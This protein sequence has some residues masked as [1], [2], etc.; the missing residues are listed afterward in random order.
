MN[1]DRFVEISANVKNYR[2]Y[3]VYYQDQTSQRLVLYKPR[4]TD[5]EDV[6]VQTGKVP[7]CLYVSLSD[8]LDFVG[9]R[10][11]EYN[12]RLRNILKGEPKASKKLLA[13]VLE[14]GL[15]V[16]VAEI[17]PR[18]RETVD[19]VLKEYM[20]DEAIVTKMIEVTVKDTST[21]VHSVNVM[22]HCLGYARQSEYDYSDLKSFGLM[23]L[24]HDVGKLNIPDSILKAPRRL[25]VEEFDL[26]KTHPNHGYDI[27]VQSRLEKRIR[28]GAL[29]HHERL[30]GSGY[31]RNLEGKDLLPE[32]K[33]LAIIDVYEA[34]TN[35]RPYK[36]PV[37]S[38]KALEIIKED[39]EKGKLDREMFQTF[40]RSLVGTRI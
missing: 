9:S 35:W 11:K 28:L 4:N 31:P 8:Q 32:S 22:L 36:D 12:E 14:L 34:L 26:I 39:V 25:T 17:A 15:T 2:K 16:P 5:I 6:R 27:L 33:A 1:I 20:D 24:F 7:K 3:D 10:H 23:G 18:M 21:S 37:S 38:L 19:I 29:Q 30:D 40:A 13:D